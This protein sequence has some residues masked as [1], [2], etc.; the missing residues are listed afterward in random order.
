MVQNIIVDFKVLPAKARCSKCKAEIEIPPTKD[1]K[2]TMRKIKELEKQHEN[3]EE[4]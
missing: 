1:L 2:E 3:C 4:V